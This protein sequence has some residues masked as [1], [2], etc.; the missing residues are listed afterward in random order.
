M[1]IYI[2][3]VLPAIL[4]HQSRVFARYRHMIHKNFDLKA[5][6]PWDSWHLRVVEGVRAGRFEADVLAKLEWPPHPRILC[7]KNSVEMIWNDVFSSCYIQNW[8]ILAP[9]LCHPWSS[10]NGPGLAVAVG[11]RHHLRPFL[12]CPWCVAKRS[13][14]ETCFSVTPNRWEIPGFK[15]AQRG[16]YH[17]S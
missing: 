15:W 3:P 7:I 9:V 8:G 6:I 17:D 12:G 13:D 4:L 16:F 1:Y 11:F 5:G 10:S 14:E 2:Y